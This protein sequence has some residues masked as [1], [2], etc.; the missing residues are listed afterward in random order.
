MNSVFSRLACTWSCN[1]CL[2][3]PFYRSGSIHHW[4][5]RRLLRWPFI[6][7]LLCKTRL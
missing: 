3:H 6:T 2:D 4:A 7:W 5:G 1:L